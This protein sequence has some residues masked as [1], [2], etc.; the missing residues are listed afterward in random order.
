MPNACK[1]QWSFLL[2]PMFLVQCVSADATSDCRIL[3][4]PD[5][6][7]LG[8]RLG[9]YFQI[10]SSIVISISDPIES[11]DSVL[12]AGLFVISFLF[13]VIYSTIRNDFPTGVQIS[14]TWYPS[15]VFASLWPAHY[16]MYL[17]PTRKGGRRT[18]LMTVLIVAT[19]SLNVWFW[20]K[21]LDW[22][23]PKQCMTPRVFLFANFSANGNVRTFFK[24]VNVFLIICSVGGTCYGFWKAARRPAASLPS[25]ATHRTH[26]I[27]ELRSMYNTMAYPDQDKPRVPSGIYGTFL[28]IH[29]LH[30]AF[31]VVASELQLHWNHLDGVNS[32]NST[33]QII[34]LVLGSLSLLRALFL[35]R[36]GDWSQLLECSDPYKIMRD[37]FLRRSE[38]L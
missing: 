17:Y 23:D 4:D 25:R 11:A 28:V 1:L 13:A 32:I 20:F 35:S 7:G 30:A 37:D 14:C 38:S 24:I 16:G 26:S 18:F 3:A 15:L 12:P 9:L 31:Y 10:F 19:A 8:V 36:K 6:L 5:I 34:P 29:F 27:S 22:D 2:V 33:G 21:G